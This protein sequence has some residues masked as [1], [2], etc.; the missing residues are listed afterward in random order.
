MKKKKMNRVEA[1]AV[2]SMMVKELF[3]ILLK[4]A[5]DYAK[6]YMEKD[7]RKRG[8]WA[9][10]VQVFP[11]TKEE[12]KVSHY[13]SWENCR[14]VVVNAND[15]LI[16]T[17]EGGTQ[18]AF[19]GG[20]S[21]GVSAPALARKGLRKW[22]NL[23]SHGKFAIPAY[24]HDE[25]NRLGGVNFRKPGEETWT[26]MRVTNSI[27]ALLMF[28]FC[29]AIDGAT[30]LECSGIYAALKTFGKFSWNAHRK[31]EKRMEND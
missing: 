30:N 1:R 6:N 27:G 18:Y 25:V 29:T 15:P 20:I 10:Q 12:A 19:F 31:R 28:Q 7:A 4:K 14:R 21:D 9:G 11:A 16:F 2:Q 24:A 23:E 17:H 22:M 8:S 13:R 3:A 5:W 26:F